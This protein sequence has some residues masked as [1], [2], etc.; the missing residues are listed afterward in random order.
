MVYKNF[1]LRVIFSLILI[2][3]YLIIAIINFSLVYYLV[4]LIYFFIILEVFF[5]F[6]KNKF[7]VILYIL[8]SLLFFSFLSF[9]Q[10]N[11]LYFNLF[12]FIVINFDIFSYLIGKI[13]GKNKFIKISPNKTIEG[14]FGGF[15]ISF[16]LSTLFAMMIE[17]SINFYFLLFVFF[18]IFS[19]FLGDLI[20]SYFKRKN[21]LKNSSEFLPGHG[22]VFD[23]F[24]SFLFSIFFYSIF[25]N[26]FL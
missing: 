8:I 9:D 3:I 17:I 13:F 16:L 18:I 10:E 25:I 26:Y 12:I 22:G 2:S 14:L 20:E 21:N 7:N 24:D 4:L 11:F 6:N 15:L 5:N 19:S 1:L 23:R